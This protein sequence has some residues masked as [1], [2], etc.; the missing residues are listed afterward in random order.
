VDIETADSILRKDHINKLDNY[1]I[2]ERIR[3]ELR[4]ILEI[5]ECA[6]TVFALWIAGT[7][8]HD[9]FNAYPYLWFNGVKGSGKTT[10]L[11]FI[12]HTAY[13]SEINMRISNPALFRQVDQYH[14]SLCYDE[15][16]NLLARGGKHSDDQDR[17]SL[18]N[19][20]YRR[21]GT[22][23]LV[24]K[25]GDNFIVRK[26]NSYS[27]K[28]MASIQPIEETLQSRSI[29]INMMVALDPKKSDESID[30]ETAKIIRKELYQFRF[31]NGVGFYISARDK[32]KNKILRKKYDLKNRDWELFKPILLLADSICP[33]WLDEVNQFLNHQKI[34]RRIDDQFSTDYTILL[35]I[36]EMVDEVENLS[37]DGKATISYKAMI[38]SLK[39]DYPELKYLTNR[40]IG[41]ALRRLGLSGMICRH[42]KGYVLKIDNKLINEQLKRLDMSKPDKSP[43]KMEEY[44]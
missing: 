5:E 41:N 44:F 20:G 15:A 24:E 21:G 33:D 25:D 36:S 38:T 32:K 27:P 42:G 11:E 23:R 43:K 18:F 34:I 28:A 6:S 14:C 40:S 4:R 37:G 22:V 9:A 16:E 30:E 10:A 17:I 29:L 19:G 7:Y 35:K 3:T 31:A 12:W 8:I 13:H 2:F 1:S 39:E 26:F